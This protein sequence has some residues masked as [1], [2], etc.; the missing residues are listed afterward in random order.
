MI[1]R[2]PLWFKFAAVIVSTISVVCLQEVNYQTIDY[3]RHSYFSNMFQIVSMMA[4]SMLIVWN[5]TWPAGR[6]I[7]ANFN[8]WRYSQKRCRF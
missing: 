4:L 1:Q 8:G 7:M 2:S 3:L 6:G 5:V